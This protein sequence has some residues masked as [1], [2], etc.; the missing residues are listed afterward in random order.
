MFQSISQRD[1]AVIQAGVLVSALAFV[2]VNLAVDLL[3]GLIDPR[4]RA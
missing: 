1:V 3:Q 2:L 4:T